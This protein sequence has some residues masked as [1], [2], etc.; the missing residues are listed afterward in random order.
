MESAQVDGVTWW[1]EFTKIIVPKVW[2]TVALQMVLLTC[3]IFSSSVQ[4]WLLTRGEYG[5]HTI[6]SWMYMQ[7]LNGSGGSYKSGVFNYMSAA[8]LVLTTIA[9]ILSI[10]VRKWTDK[11]FEE[12]EF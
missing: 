7:L 8:G 2:P 10:T 1:T 6:D 12:V 9:V 5:T 3:S 11:A 4:V